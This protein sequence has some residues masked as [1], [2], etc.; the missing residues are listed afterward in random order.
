[1]KYCFRCGKEFKRK[2]NLNLHLNIKKICQAKY[3]DLDRQ[4]IRNEYNIH[5]KIS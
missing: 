5:E 3:L 4:V 2:S 1:M